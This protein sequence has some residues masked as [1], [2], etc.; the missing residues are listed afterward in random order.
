MEQCKSLKRSFANKHLSLLSSP[1][2]NPHLVSIGKSQ[3]LIFMD[4]GI[5]DHLA[6]LVLLKVCFRRPVAADSKFYHFI[7]RNGLPVR[8]FGSSCTQ[9]GVGCIVE[10]EFKPSVIVIVITEI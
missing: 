6:E 1:I 10:R 3:L 4:F 7:K 8:L 9:F 2:F 5:Y